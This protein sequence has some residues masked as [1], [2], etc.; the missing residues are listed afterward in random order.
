MRGAFSGGAFSGFE[1]EGTY[2]DGAIDEVR[3]IRIAGGVVEES[4]EGHVDGERRR[5]VGQAEKSF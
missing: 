3:L 2:F 1:K 5:G 4:L